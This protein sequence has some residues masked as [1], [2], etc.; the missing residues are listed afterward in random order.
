MEDKSLYGYVNA[1]YPAS[2]KQQQ[3][4]CLQEL[5]TYTEWFIYVINKNEIEDD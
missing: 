3:F 2:D 5:L 1:K 4:R